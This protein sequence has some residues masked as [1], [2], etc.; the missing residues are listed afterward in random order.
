MDSGLR[1]SILSEDQMFTSQIV[2]RLELRLQKYLVH[3]DLIV[4]SLQEF[5]IILGMDWLSSHGGVNDFRQRLVYVIQ[6]NGK[7]FVF[8]ATRHQQ[9]SHVI[10]CLCA[11]KL[12]KRGFHSFLASIVSVTEPVSQRL[13]DVDVVSEFS[14]VFPEDVS[15]IPPDRE[16]DFSIELMLGTVPISKAPYRLA[17]AEMKELKGQIQDLLD[18]RFIRPSFSPWDAPVLFVKKK[19]G[20]M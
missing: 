3:A 17:P 15:G 8:E 7:P 16:V 12:I 11:R 1:V 2:K 9:F 4:L 13:E 14:S 19:E 6:P 10:S 18:K 5:D 20:N